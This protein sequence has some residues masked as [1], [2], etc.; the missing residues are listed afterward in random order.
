MEHNGRFDVIWNGSAKPEITSYLWTGV[1]TGQFYKFRHR[2]LNKNGASEY[3][4]VLLT[5][6]CELPSKPATPSWVTSTKTSISIK[7]MAPLDDGGCPIR[8]YQILR[9][10][11]GESGLAEISVHSTDLEDKYWIDSFDITDLPANSL[12]KRFSF[13]VRVYTDFAVDGVSSLLSP[14]M[15]LGDRPDKPSNAPTRNIET[16]EFTV[17]V[18][19]LQVP[20]DNGSPITSYNV[21]VDD[22]LGGE[23][24]EI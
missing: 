8:Q 24:T 18:N 10:N 5:W 19:I 9:N 20:G 13:V 23:F 11:G 17:A 1:E 12:G 22:G 4:D 14:S 2:V 7:W 21:E 3:S 6:A 15:I 16:S